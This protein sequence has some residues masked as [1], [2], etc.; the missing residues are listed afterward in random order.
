MEQKGIRNFERWQESTYISPFARSS[1]A[2]VIFILAP[3]LK[4]IEMN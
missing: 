2:I 1:A 4:R 3:R